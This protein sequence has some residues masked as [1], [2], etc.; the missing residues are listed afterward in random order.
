MMIILPP[1]QKH[2]AV[3]SH[4]PIYRSNTTTGPANVSNTL[5]SVY[6]TVYP[7]TGALLPEASVTA[8]S[9]GVLTDSL[10][11]EGLL[12]GFGLVPQAFNVH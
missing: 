4:G 1:S 3:V 8:L 10:P 6:G 2:G 7:R 12:R 11:I 9:A 5:A